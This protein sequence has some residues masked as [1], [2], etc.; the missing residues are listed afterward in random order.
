MTK[1]IPVP[2]ARF[3]VRILLLAVAAAATGGAK[4]QIPAQGLPPP[5][6][7]AYASLQAA[8]GELERSADT[9]VAEV[10][11]RKIT[12][13]D[14]ADTI[15]AMPAIVGGVPFPGLYQRAAIELMQQEAM[16]VH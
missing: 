6:V 4:A 2:L 11:P 8:V 3:M 14:I 7:G 16:A 12:W 1:V 13:G 5:D 9:V 15:R 10:G